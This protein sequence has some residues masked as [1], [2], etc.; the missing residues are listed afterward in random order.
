MGKYAL[1]ILTAIFLLGADVPKQGAFANDKTVGEKL[2]EAFPG[3]EVENSPIVIYFRSKRLLIAADE[4]IFEADGKV[5]LTGCAIAR[6]PA[7]TESAKVSRPTTIRCQFARIKLDRP[8]HSIEEL[9]HR[10]IVSVELSGG[11]RL[12]FKD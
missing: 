2:R 3:G 12:S 4:I 10:K 8:A 5:K 7:T 9:L 6:F 1:M 11:V